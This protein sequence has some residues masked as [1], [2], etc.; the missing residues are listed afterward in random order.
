MKS[1][2][3][4]SRREREIM[5]IIYALDG[6]TALQVL[7]RLPVPP[8]Y[9]AVRALLRILERKGHLTHHREGPRYVFSPVLPREKARKSALRHL[10]KTFF[11]DS[12]ED[13]VAA[14]LDIS[15]AGL[16]EDEYRRL[17]E[18]VNRARREGR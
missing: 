14:L 1:P 12:A 6:A 18:L 2:K 4:L 10:V 13:V 5:D 16:T 3:N 8:C 17:L 11:D 9:S 7:E 15:E